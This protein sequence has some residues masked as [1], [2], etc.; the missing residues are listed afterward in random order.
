MWRLCETKP[1][2]L[3]QYKEHDSSQLINV[4]GEFNSSSGTLYKQGVHIIHV[5]HHRKSFS[6]DMAWCPPSEGQTL[7]VATWQD[8]YAFIEMCLRVF[9]KGPNHYIC[10]TIR[11][12][13]WPLQPGT[14]VCFTSIYATFIQVDGTYSQTEV[15]QDAFIIS[16]RS[17]WKPYSIFLWRHM[18]N[19]AADPCTKLSQ[20]LHWLES[21][22]P[23]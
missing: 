14:Q 21:L 1:S 9:S 19:F 17:A 2:Y 16:E 11:P 3:Q 8:H 23:H 5:H 6:C 22:L 12:R 20:G 7:Y 15:G 13:I 4:T 18:C 10:S